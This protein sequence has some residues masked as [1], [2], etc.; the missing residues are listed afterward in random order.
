[1][2]D[3]P[4]PPE[5]MSDES[6]PFKALIRTL[7]ALSLLALFFSAPLFAQSANPPVTPPA[8]QTAAQPAPSGTSSAD[9]IAIVPLADAK[10]GE[11][12]T[13][14]G[15]L[16]VASG[17]AILFA[18]GTVS[19]GSQTTDVL[20]P[21]RGTLRVCAATSVKLAADTSVPAGGSQPGLL[22]A[23]DHGALEASFA[24]GRNADILLTPDFRILISGPGSADV[25][26]R[27]GE[28]GDTCVDNPLVQGS[29]PY[30]LVTSVFDGSVY[31]VQPGQRVMFQHG[32]THE[33]V[34]SEREPCGCPA[35]VHEGANEFPLAQSAG[36]APLARP[37]PEPAQPSGSK[38]A[39]TAPLVYQS[40]T[41]APAP[42]P[43]VTA[44]TE[45][46][47]QSAP[48]PVP[49]KPHKAKEKKQHV[50]F[51]RSVGHFFRRLF[52]AE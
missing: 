52:G 11:G 20:L 44:S 8:N 6:G 27:L 5:P 2:H 40:P 10:S 19:S 39:A 21:R 24:T 36:L 25:K 46:A 35:P 42:A 26:V 51:F 31:R 34:D 22:M 3:E 9:P 50:G 1:M 16:Q 13:V 15:A 4:M 7:A 30:V 18:S 28:H 32:S 14:T 45:P 48:A 37:V 49:T 23:L 17:K 12:A 43:A 38:P 47:V 33:G 41:A 29:A